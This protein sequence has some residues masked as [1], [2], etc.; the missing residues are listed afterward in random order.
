MNR[1]GE[2]LLS[3]QT[4]V[5]GR[6]TCTLA[7][8]VLLSVYL[9]IDTSEMKF[10]EIS[11]SPT[12]LSSAATLGLA[13]FSLSLIVHWVGDI[14]SS[15]LIGFGWRRKTT[16]KLFDEGGDDISHLKSVLGQLDQLL[17]QDDLKPASLDD[18]ERK[19]LEAVRKQLDNLARSANW[20]NSYASFYVL[21]WSFIVP[22]AL[23]VVAGYSLMSN[24]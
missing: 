2:P 3:R 13:F 19:G 10:L 22:L 14:A 15:S 21:I 1:G 23:A 16:G 7:V 17:N 11:I 8:S 5:A 6:A 20:F 12:Q 9:D 18:S 4:I 24:A